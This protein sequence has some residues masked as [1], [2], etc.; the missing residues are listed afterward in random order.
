MG[1]EWD[2]VPHHPHEN[3]VEND[4]IGSGVR[5]EVISVSTSPNEWKADS[6]MNQAFDQQLSGIEQRLV[7]IERRLQADECSSLLKKP[8]YSCR[9]LAELTLAHGVWAYR[10]FTI[11]CA[12][13]DGRIA[14]AQKLTNGSWSIPRRA[15]ERILREGLRPERRKT[16]NADDRSK[17]NQ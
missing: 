12:C 3:P 10:P 8:W 9:E 7:E 13:S 1:F 14:D 6:T 15:V 16:A 5:Q 11:R 2:H 17:S 4:A